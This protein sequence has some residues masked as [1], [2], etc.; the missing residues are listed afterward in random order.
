MLASGYAPNCIKLHIPGM[1]E[2]DTAALSI[3][4]LDMRYVLSLTS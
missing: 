4:L 3:L 2:Y 1:Y